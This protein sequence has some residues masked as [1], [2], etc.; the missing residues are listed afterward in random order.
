MNI[1]TKFFYR[2]DWSHEEDILLLEKS[3]LFGRRW[4]KIAQQLMNRNENSV[5]NRFIT[6]TK[7]IKKKKKQRNFDL[8]NNKVINEIKEL[9][10]SLKMK[11]PEPAIKQEAKVLDSTKNHQNL[12]STSHKEKEETN[13]KKNEFS[14]LI[15]YEKPHFLIEEAFH[16]HLDN[17]F[18]NI[19]PHNEINKECLDNFHHETQNN[20]SFNYSGNPFDTNNYYKKSFEYHPLFG[21]EE[22]DDVSPTK[23]FTS[24]L[25]KNVNSQ[26]PHLETEF[27]NLKKELLEFKK[28]SA[29]WLDSEDSIISEEDYLQKKKEHDNCNAF[30]FF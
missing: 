24:F 28:N 4:A 25:K 11:I 16:Q 22:D 29:K 2:G 10:N 15:N 12:N 5:K 6:L 23:H 3:L 1:K 26:T 17:N 7:S 21:E 27:Q 9:I 18:F 30:D 20:P 13:N 8:S 19:T 14:H